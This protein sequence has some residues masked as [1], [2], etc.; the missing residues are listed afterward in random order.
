EAYVN[1]KFSHTAYILNRIAVKV[2]KVEPTRA[3]HEASYV[4]SEE[5]KNQSQVYTRANEYQ[6]AFWRN[7][8]GVYDIAQGL[9][10]PTVRNVPVFPDK[11]L[12]PGDSWQAKGSEVQDLRA[13]GISAPFE[14]PMDVN[15]RYEGP[16]DRNGQKRQLITAKYK[17]S[18]R[19]PRPTTGQVSYP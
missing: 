18:Y 7:S 5:S 14:Y 8:F 10:V 19:V 4:T 3:W 1:G 9:Y 11:D 6:A 2:S 12:Q 13:I 17:L 15:Y 16:Q